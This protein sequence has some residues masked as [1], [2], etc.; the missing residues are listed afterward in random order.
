MKLRLLQLIV[1]TAGCL[2]LF[3]IC[4]PDCLAIFNDNECE[5]LHFRSSNL[6]E[7][8]NAPIPKADTINI[9]TMADT[10]SV[11]I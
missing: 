9:I 8:Q 4:F 5:K 1:L 6:P 11:V 7:T 10:L 2:G 3:F